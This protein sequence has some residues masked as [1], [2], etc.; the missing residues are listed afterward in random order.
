MV[1]MSR[2]MRA[3]VWP[4]GV[5]RWPGQQG[6]QGVLDMDMDKC[7]RKCQ[8]IGAPESGS[9]FE[10]CKVVGKHRVSQV[11]VHML[12][13][14]HLEHRDP[15]LASSFHC[16]PHSATLVITELASHKVHLI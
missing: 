12:A 9:R 1:N 13:Q 15:C 4:E 7:M 8:D 16:L 11:S 6:P 14:V 2:V 3:P 10:C 5:G